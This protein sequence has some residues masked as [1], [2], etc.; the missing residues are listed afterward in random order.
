MQRGISAH[1]EPL[2]WIQVIMIAD[3]DEYLVVPM[4][5]CRLNVN[6]GAMSHTFTFI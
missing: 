4:A 2:C 3:P 5:M 1:N 6:G